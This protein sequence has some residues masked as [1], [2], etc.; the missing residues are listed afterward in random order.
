[1]WTIDNMFGDLAHKAKQL[2][3]FFSIMKVKVKQKT[4]LPWE[5]PS[6]NIVLNVFNCELTFASFD[7]II[8]IGITYPFILAPL[9]IGLVVDYPPS[10]ILAH[11]EFPQCLC[12]T[13]QT[14]KNM[15]LESQI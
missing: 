13:Q 15:M 9:S 4:V 8:T 3:M 10:L 11:N 2:N 6:Q 1:M 5:A 7:P 14:K 12:R